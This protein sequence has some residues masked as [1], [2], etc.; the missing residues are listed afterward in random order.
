MIKQSQREDI[1]KRNREIIERA[2][3]ELRNNEPKVYARLSTLKSESD[4]NQAWTDFKV[5]SGLDLNFVPGFLRGSH[6]IDLINFTK[7]SG[8]IFESNMKQKCFLSENMLAHFDR[9]SC[10]L[11]ELSGPSKV[12]RADESILEDSSIPKFADSNKRV[13]AP[14]SM[15]PVRTTANQVSQTNIAIEQI[16]A[17]YTTITTFSSAECL[18]DIKILYNPVTKRKQRVKKV[19]KI[20]PS[21]AKLSLLKFDDRDI[22]DLAGLLESHESFKA[23]GDIPK[24]FTLL[25]EGG[26][27][28]AVLGFGRSVTLFQSGKKHLLKKRNQNSVI[29]ID[30]VR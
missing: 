18:D 13:V 7:F 28:F 1:R 10:N 11:P 6:E 20:L 9:L 2:N 17:K 26:E 3:A 5:P 12:L 15:I 29:K 21:N 19:A 25:N 22:A 24:R 30:L 14:V 4:I 16:D 27:D 8:N 23:V